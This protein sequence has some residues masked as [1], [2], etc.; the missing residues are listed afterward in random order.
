MSLKACAERMDYAETRHAGVAN[1]VVVQGRKIDILE[2]IRERLELSGKWRGYQFLLPAKKALKWVH[3]HNASADS[4]ANVTESD[5][6]AQVSAVE[7]REMVSEAGLRSTAKKADALARYVSWMQKAGQ[8][9]G[10]GPLLL[11]VK[12]YG[13]MSKEE[14]V[15]VVKNRLAAYNLVAKFSSIEDKLTK[16]QLVEMLNQHVGLGLMGKGKA[17][18]IVFGSS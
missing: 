1:K 2:S 4:I 3:D 12:E 6:L 7:I 15:G 5:F 8:W 18:E 16:D 17:M 10:Y 13:S 9:L 11:N 14:L